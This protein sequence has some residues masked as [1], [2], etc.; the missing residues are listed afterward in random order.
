MLENIPAFAGGIPSH[1]TFNWVFSA[2][3]PEEPEKSFIALTQAVVG[4]TEGEV[5][6]RACAGQEIGA[7]KASCI[8]QR[9]GARE[10]YDFG[11]GKSG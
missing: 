8:G 7:T 6:G 10:L 2:L 4:L 5:M 1:D 3:E 11:S 9:P